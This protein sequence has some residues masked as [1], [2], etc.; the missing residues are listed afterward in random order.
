MK[1]E[2]EQQALDELDEAAEYAAR[3]AASIETG[4]RL[5]EEVAAAERSIEQFPNAWPPAG[6]RSVRRFI[7]STFPYQIIYRVEGET[8]RIYAVAPV[9]SDG[10][11]TGESASSANWDFDDKSC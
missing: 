8:I 10:Q 4:F 11:A 1:V 6:P 2:Y 7:L 3:A 9:T 5:L